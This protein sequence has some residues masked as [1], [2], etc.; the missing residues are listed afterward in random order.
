MLEDVRNWLQEIGL[1]EYATA[2]IENAVSPD[3]LP[4]LNNDDLKDLGVDKLGD[5]KKLLLAIKR[6][7][8]D[9]AATTPAESKFAPPTSS[10]AQAERRQVTVMFIDL[11]GSTALSTQLDAEDYRDLIR[12]YQDAC[13]GVVA[14]YEGFVAKYMGDGILVYFGWPHAHEDD[15]E[16][17]VNVGLE[18]LD[19]VGVLDRGVDGS[20]SVRIGIATGSVVVGDIV[21]QGAA[22]EAAIVGEA[23]NLAARLQ[24]IADLNSIV[25]ADATHRIAGGLFECTDLGS[26]TLKGFDAPVNAWRVDAGRAIESRFEATRKQALTPFVG[27]EEE[28][29]TLLRRWQRAI[30]GKGQVV[31]LSGEPGI[32]KSR[33]I[34]ALEER[35]G[36]Q[37]FTRLRYQCSP[38]HATSALHPVIRQIE[39][40]ARI[41]ADDTADAKL[42]KLEMLLAKPGRP[43]APIV[44]LIAPL[45]S[46]PFGHRYASLEVSPGHQK[47]LMLEALVDQLVGLAAQRPVLFHFEDAHWIDP[48]TMQLM[49][50]IIERTAEIAALVVVSFRPSF[51]P[52]WTG[53]NHVTSMS[54][55]RLDPQTCFELAARVS[56]TATL[57]ADVIREIVARTD[58]LPLF[59][60]EVTKS[61]NEAAKGANGAT[62][63]VA[64]PATIQ[65]SL[66]ARLDRLGPVKEAAQIASVIGRTFRQDVMASVMAVDDATLEAAL[67]RL[68]EAGL[69]HRRPI[70]GGLGFEFKHALAQEAAYQSIL[71]TRRRHYHARTAEVLESRFKEV[72][73]PELIAHHHTEAA[74]F[75]RA[76]DWWLEAC[77][78]AMQRSAHL[79]AESHL[80]R[81]LDLLEALD[82][83]AARRRCEI[84]LRNTLGVCIMPTRGFGNPEVAAAFTR[85]AELC[86]RGSDDRALFVALRGKGQYNMVSGDM[87]GACNDTARILDLAHRLDDR[88]LRMEAHHLGW[89]ALCFKGEYHSAQRHAEEGIAH[90]DRD[91]DHH[92]TYVYSGHDPG[93]CC[94]A[95]GSLSLAQLGLHDQALSLCEDGIALAESLQH[96]FSLAVALWATGLLHQLRRAPAETLEVGDRMI[97][98]CTESG[99]PPMVPLGKVFRGDSLARLGEA[100]EGI[101]LMRDGIA[102]LRAH[103]TLFSLPSFFPALADAYARTGD[104]DN[105]METIEDGLGAAEAG[106]DHFSLPEAH[107]IKASLLLARSS[108]DRPAAEAS[109]RTA[110]AVAGRQDAKL[111]QLRAR[112]DLARL[113]AE[114]GRRSDAVDLLSAAL[115]K[116][117]EGFDTPDLRDAK[118]LMEALV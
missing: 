101:A 45:L 8:A 38:Y 53:D 99:L 21:G 72:A 111:L 85:A 11:A 30:D 63:P 41:G 23:P 33:I 105:A 116:F 56:R 110:I 68:V 102:E 32:G 20:L 44:P 1:S 4:H 91:R 75:E 106:S 114:T 88:D 24:S 10:E 97:A 18:I 16:R 79:E 77:Q 70:L 115:P 3:L 109:Y 58:G 76:I 66:M 7:D 19:A 65:D 49:D 55:N 69:L 17:A 82:D 73:E 28:I 78:H 64:I 12:S 80:H 59:V 107:R 67:N 15:A 74:R 27:R 22:Q 87:R 113:L 62:G 92:L 5:R 43:I 60:E 52:S 26:Q 50:L 6:L 31:L 104:V 118:A 89:S 2:F 83:P 37:S 117:S 40:A 94:R 46:I 100:A 95:F 35:I 98:Y 42:D 93:V 25:I 57:S 51:S 86:E 61:V 13:A 14:Q 103:G 29:G 108:E 84:A 34:N 54:L 36:D 71:R 48:T 39:R 112:T 96:P 90:Y 9:D 47:Q 81:G